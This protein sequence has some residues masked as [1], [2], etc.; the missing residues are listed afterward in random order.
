MVLTN[1]GSSQDDFAGNKNEEDNTWLH[2]P[3]DIRC[4]QDFQCCQA[5]KV[6]KKAPVDETGKQLRLVTGELKGNQWNIQRKT[7][8]KMVLP[9]YSC[10]EK[11]DQGPESVSA[12]GPPA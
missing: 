1:L 9:Q 11:N 7:K 5:K 8:P 10:N 3:D 4:E 12:Q 6:K 2:H